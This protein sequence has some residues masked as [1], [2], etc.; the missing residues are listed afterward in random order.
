MLKKKKKNVKRLSGEQVKKIPVVEI[1]DDCVYVSGKKVLAIVHFKGP[2]GEIMR[3]GELSK[4]RRGGY[5]F[6]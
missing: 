1:L 3:T 6:E 4:T 5:L 2:R